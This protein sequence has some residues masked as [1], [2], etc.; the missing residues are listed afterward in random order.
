MFKKRYLAPLLGCAS[1]M[2]IGCSDDGDEDKNETPIIKLPEAVSVIEKQSLVI[3]AEVIDD[4]HVDYQWQQLSGINVELHNDTAMQLSITAPSVTRNEQIELELTATD[5]EGEVAKAK[6]QVDINQAWLEGQV[7]GQ[8]QSTHEQLFNIEAKLGDHVFTSQSNPQ[9]EF[10]LNLRFD[11]DV[12][13]E[14]DGALF[15]VSAQAFDSPIG[16]KAY[17]NKNY[18]QTKITILQ[19]H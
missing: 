19:P 11:D 3:E 7:V 18:Q 15:N 6:I 13:F 4:G 9:G 5:A 2:L 1:L 8:I 16:Y 14:P 10:T 17:I 12:V